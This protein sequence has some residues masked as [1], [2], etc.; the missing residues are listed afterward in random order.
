LHPGLIK[1]T[2]CIYNVLL[3]S[4]GVENWICW[5]GG[6][7]WINELGR[8]GLEAQRCWQGPGLG[9]RHHL[10]NGLRFEG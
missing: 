10:I 9:P 5:L 2:H 7:V 1:A 6:S 4:L 8:A 3:A